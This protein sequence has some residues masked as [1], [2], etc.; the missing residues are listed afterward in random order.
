[1]VS[2]PEVEARDEYLEFLDFFRNRYQD[3]RDAPETFNDMVELLTPM[4]ELRS[5]RHPFFLFQ[6]SCLCLTSQMRNLPAV[7]CPGVDKSDLRCRLTDVI[8]P[9]QYYL[10]N[11]AGSVAVCTTESCLYKYRELESSFASGNV[12][13][14]FWVLIHSFGKANFPKTLISAQK[15]LRDKPRSG[16]RSLTSSVSS[17]RGRSRNRSPNKNNKGV[18]FG[19]TSF[20]DAP[21][22]TGALLPGSS[23]V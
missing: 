10:S 14:D 18:N 23:K 5:R 11:V 15:A 3:F 21:A 12:A 22:P 20:S 1:M 2:T 8:V 17:T 16:K 6:L 19:T 13:G 4:P 7:K 9:A